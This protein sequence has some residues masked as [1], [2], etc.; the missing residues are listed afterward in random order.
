M[1]HFNMPDYRTEM[2]KLQDHWDKAVKEGVFKDARKPP[3]PAPDIYSPRG[4][5]N[6]G[7]SP[8]MAKMASQSEKMNDADYWNAIFKLSRGEQVVNLPTGGRLDPNPGNCG[9]L[10]EG[11]D[12]PAKSPNPVPLWTKGNDQEY[13]PSHW[14]DVKDLE[15]LSK[16]KEELHALGDKLATH[17]AKE[18]KAKAEAA[19]K[20]I[21]NLQKEITDLSNFL[22]TPAEE[23]M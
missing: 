14:F 15:K 20:K 3:V 6:F 16:M 13:Q 22:T 4:D 23:K 2:E 10:S 17:D 19:F 1:S 7:M 9:I 18:E 21:T 11:D 5:V 8:E 12:W